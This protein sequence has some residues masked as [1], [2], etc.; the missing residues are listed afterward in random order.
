ME[1]FNKMKTRMRKIHIDGQVWVWYCNCSYVSEYH[2]QELGIKNPITGKWVRVLVRDI[3][4]LETIK[5]DRSSWDV[6]EAKVYKI[7]PEMVKKY[8]LENLI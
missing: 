2:E 8:I 6:D 1:S 3:G 7:T 5:V 4:E